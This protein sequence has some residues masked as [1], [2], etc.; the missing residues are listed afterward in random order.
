[1]PATKQYVTRRQ[2]EGKNQR[3]II[4]CLK[5]HIAQETHHLTTNPPPTPNC[6]ELHNRRQHHGITVTQAAHHLDTQPTL[7]PRPERGLYHNHQLATRYQH[8][9]NT[10][11]PT[12]TTP[13]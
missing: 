9:I 10:R 13:E 5:Q 7:L 6:P 12:C 8:W 3:E 4:R 11:Q 1:M 2:A